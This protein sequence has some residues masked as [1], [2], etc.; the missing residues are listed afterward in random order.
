MRV[1][2]LAERSGVAASTLRYYEDRGLLPAQRSQAGYRLYDQRALQRLAFITT[3]K[4]LGLDLAEIGELTAIWADRPCSQVKATLKPRLSHRL[5]EA[6]RR[7]AELEGF[8]ALL[9]GALRRLDELP[10]RDT[11]CDPG[12]ASLDA[13]PPAP[14]EP[15]PHAR[16]TVAAATE[17]PSCSLDAGDHRQRISR[18]RLL[19]RQGRR[20]PRPQGSS[21]SLPLSQAGPLA[22]L[23]AAERRCCSFLRLRIDF[24]TQGVRLHARLD[25]RRRPEP[26]SP[27]WQAA[28]LLGAL[29]DDRAGAAEEK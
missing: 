13:G 20:T 26:G 21:W 5:A 8:R 1:S 7:S 10:D 2:E 28:R 18:W 17:A 15:L 24:T 12:C 29:G 3:A 25:A 27:A 23:A 16:G 14:A 11:P 9:A 6:E 22:E 4:K 19:L